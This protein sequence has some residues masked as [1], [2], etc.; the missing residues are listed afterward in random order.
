MEETLK[1]T[2]F[3]AVKEVCYDND[4]YKERYERDLITLAT[5]RLE[6]LLKNR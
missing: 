1:N 4:N 5:L 6:M 3:A 2:F